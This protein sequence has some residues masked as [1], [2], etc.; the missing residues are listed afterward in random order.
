[1]YLLGFDVGST[2]VMASLVDAST[3]EELCSVVHPQ[4]EMEIISR[5]PGWAEQNPETWWDNFV[6]CSK[7]ILQQSK[8]HPKEIISIGISYQ[9]HGLVCVDKN[10]KVL[11]PSI[12]WS[13]S[14]AVSI[15]REAFEQLGM[16]NCLESLLNSPGNFTYSKLKWVKDNEPDVYQN[17]HK[18]LLPGEYIV[19]RLTGQMETTISGLSEGILWN[20]KEKRIATEVLDYHGMNEELIPKISSN[21]DIVG[22]VCK[23]ASKET[24]LSKSTVVS[25]RAGDQPNNALSLNILKKG[26]VAA[27]SGPSGVVYGIVD[28]LMYDEQ[29]RINSFAHVNYEEHYKNIGILLCI[30]GAG[31]QYSWMKHN[32][33]R[34]NR[35]YSDMERMALSAPIGSE[36]VC[37]LPFGNGAERIFNNRNIESHIHNLQFN[38][39]SRAHVY[40]AA[41]E[42]V[43]FSFV[44][45]MNLLK[46]MGLKVNTIRVPYEN[47]FKSKVFSETISTLLQAPLEVVKT[48]SSKGAALASGVGAKVYASVNEALDKT[49]P[50]FYY[51]PKLNYAK[52]YQAYEFW[53]TFL[54]KKLK[55][56]QHSKINESDRSKIIGLKKELEKVNKLAETQKLLLDSNNQLIKEIRDTIQQHTPK[57]AKQSNETI[58]KIAKQLK[59]NNHIH[60]DI[61]NYSEHFEILNDDFIKEFKHNFK[62]LSYSDL[63]LVYYLRLN[64]STKEIA[65][66]LS[67]TVRGVETKRYRLRKKIFLT[68]DQNLISYINNF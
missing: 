56:A 28:H 37:I 19:A 48:N 2:H 65:N 33:A 5:Q 8:V 16:N 52:C 24:K 13:D 44:H 14:R 38:R 10:I 25:Y 40:R 34:S 57:N 30:N 21:F 29:S 66:R 58:K 26:E 68:R 64:L 42:G 9:M 63:Q 67:I 39:H 22:K 55:P 54:N 6:L 7:Q 12:I 11:R 18:V 45:G 4:R 23:A 51:E 53:Q 41:L 35:T 46:E 60:Y 50:D 15:G 31:T 1:M 27:T 17:I 32:V 36:G 61:E 20:F 62:N 3:Q 59:Q 49:V 47:M 43:S